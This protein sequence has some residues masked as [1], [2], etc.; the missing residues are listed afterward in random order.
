[1]AYPNNRELSDSQRQMLAW[2]ERAGAMS[3]SRVAAETRTPPEETWANLDRLAELGYVVVR[4]DPDSADGTLVFIT[5][6]S[7][8]PDKKKPNE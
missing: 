2:I 1:M 7:R 6:K 3:P 8:R 4:D 5:P